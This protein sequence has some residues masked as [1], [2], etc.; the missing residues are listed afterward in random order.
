MILKNVNIS[1][2]WGTHIPMLMK[3]ISLTDKKVVE[4]GAGIISTNFLHWFCRE[5]N[6]KMITYEQDDQYFHFA[7]SFVSIL[8]KVVKVT[9]WDEISAEQNWGVLLIDNYPERR[10]K[11]LIK[12]KDSADYIV[13]HDTD[14]PEQYGFTDEVWGLFKYKYE[15]KECHPWTTV[16]SNKVDLTIFNNK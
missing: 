10:V 1:K 8:H 2:G 9:N 16:V 14:K 4:I 15:W 7:K 5:R 6:Q 11:D 12:F 13:I 3:S